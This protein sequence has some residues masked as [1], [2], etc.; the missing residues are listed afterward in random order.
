VLQ[1]S[2]KG[3]Q[4][5]IIMVFAAD[6]WFFASP[7]GVAVAVAQSSRTASSNRLRHTAGVS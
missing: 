4:K 5:V 2:E 7:H 1:N 6:P 3:I